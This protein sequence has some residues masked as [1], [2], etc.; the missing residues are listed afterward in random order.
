MRRFGP[1]LLLVVGAVLL[2]SCTLIPTSTKPVPIPSSQGLSGLL[3]RTIP[4]TN[5]GRVQFVTQP[6][7]IVDATGHL[8]PLSRIVT[9]PATLTSVLDQLIIGPTKI[10]KSAGYA[11][12]LPS[13]LLILQATVKGKIG[14]I[15]LSQ[16]LTKLA[17][18]KALLAVGQLVFTAYYAG[19]TNGI[20][21]SVAGVPQRSPLPDRA[22]LTLVTVKDCESLL[23]P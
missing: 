15:D 3:G 9:A 10:E 17:R 2:S 18:S 4:G 20:E 23:E 21:I 8:A 13:N 12:E 7:Y 1:L 11:S 6:V 16:S 5:D 19:A 22:F 14:Y